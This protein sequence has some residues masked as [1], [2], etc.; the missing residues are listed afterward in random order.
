MGARRRLLDDIAK[1]ATGTAGLVQGAGRE[2]ETVFRVRLER[3]LDQMDLV[4][5][6]EFEVVKAMAAAAREE[7][8]ALAERVATL[9]AAIQSAQSDGK[10]SPTR[11]RSA[12]SASAGASA[13][14]GKSTRTSRKAQ[15]TAE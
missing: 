11:R 3:L 14:R 5:R 9:E 1:L 8:A 2:A 12:K 13:S 7:N 10:P 15:K 4:P 6:D